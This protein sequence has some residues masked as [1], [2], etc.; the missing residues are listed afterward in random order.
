MPVEELLAASAAEQS[1]ERSRVRDLFQGTYLRRTLFCGLFYMCQITPMFALYTFGPA[2]LGSFGLGEGN[3]S[4]LGSALISVVFVLGCLPALRLVDRVGRRPVIVWSFAL[5]VVPLAVLGGG[6]ALPMAVVIVCFCAYA[7]LSGG[8]RCWSGRIPT[9][10]SP[11][12]SG[13]PREAW[14]RRSAAS[15]PPRGR[16]CCPS[17]WTGWASG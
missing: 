8:P 16:I 11:P 4:N 2:I 12:A 10:C 17:P 9:S 13:P 6:D 15:A 14:P 7:L 3:E 5:M 1:L